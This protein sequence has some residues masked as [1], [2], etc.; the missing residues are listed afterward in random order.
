M[1]AS[2]FFNEYKRLGSLT[3]KQDLQ[4]LNLQVKYLLSNESDAAFYAKSEQDD[5]TLYISSLP[6]FAEE[7]KN[8]KKGIV[9]CG[10]NFCVGLLGDSSKVNFEEL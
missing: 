10:S 4:I 3:K 5:P 7:I 6:Q 9:Y 2:R 8:K 1:T